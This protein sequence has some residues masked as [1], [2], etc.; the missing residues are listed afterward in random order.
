M[1]E[2]TQ[3]DI[4]FKKSAEY[5]CKD[6]LLWAAK[7]I[8]NTEFERSPNEETTTH[9]KRTIV[10]MIMSALGWSGGSDCTAKIKFHKNQFEYDHYY[11]EAIFMLS[12][13][14]VNR[15]DFLDRQ[16]KSNEEIVD[17]LRRMA[18]FITA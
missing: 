3:K 15:L 1:I 14:L 16:T 10:G 2:I 12:R 9:N 11:Q 8:E 5:P 4:E 17:W 6:R 18:E 13:Y 7:I